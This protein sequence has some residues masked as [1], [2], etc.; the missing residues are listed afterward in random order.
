MIKAYLNN[1]ELPRLGN[2]LSEAVIENAADV[3]TAD[4][5]I[6]TTFAVS[7]NKRGWTLRFSILTESEF[8]S[9]KAI[10]DAQWDTYEYPLLSIPH[11]GINNVPVRMT[12]T[13]RDV[14]NHCGSVENVVI[15]LRESN[16]LS[17]WSS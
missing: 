1:I 17:S 16:Q 3:I 12:L 13:P 2:P 15:T 4:N 8:D 7:S 5:N 11:Y 14:F 9:I 6:Y 10:Y